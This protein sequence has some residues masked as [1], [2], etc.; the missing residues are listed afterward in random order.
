MRPWP[1]VALTAALSSL[2]GP[3]AAEPLRCQIHLFD[4]LSRPVVGAVV[5][6]GGVRAT[7]QPE[8]KVYVAVGDAPASSTVE[9]RARGRGFLTTTAVLGRTHDG[10]V[11]SL[12]WLRR[13]GERYLH[14][15]GLD[16]P[17]VAEADH[18]LVTLAR[19][20]RAADVQ[21]SR[22]DVLAALAP[23]LRREGLVVTTSRAR[24]RP[25]T[26]WGRCGNPED[27]VVLGRADGKP[28]PTTGVAALAA[29]R[30]EPL[31][32]TAGPLIRQEPTTDG[33]LALSHVIRVHRLTTEGVG[34]LTELAA[35][36]GATWDVRA[37]TLTLPPTLGL[38]AADV[39]NELAATLPE[40]SAELDL[41]G[42][43]GC[44]D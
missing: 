33:E 12:L 14:R 23:L 16:V 44:T 22:A 26:R 20:D 30:A 34:P 43:K 9:V 36:H 41:H 5:T 4:A 1:L 32:R 18:L 7:Y 21:R 17:F 42:P 6:C 8:T 11:S 39:M 29:L 15:S 24:P 3:A 40:V 27:E 28:F 35:R 37:M 2:A 10:A 13:R 38:G 25:A 19:Y 31:I